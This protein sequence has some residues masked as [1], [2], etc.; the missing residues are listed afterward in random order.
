MHFRLQPTDGQFVLEVDLI[1]DELQQVESLQIPL[2]Q[3][4]GQDQPRPIQLRF[5]CGQ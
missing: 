1:V 4:G 2:H 3:Q 5:G